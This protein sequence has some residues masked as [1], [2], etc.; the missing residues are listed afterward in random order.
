MGS[1]SLNGSGT[2]RTADDAAS[3]AKRLARLMNAAHVGDYTFLCSEPR[4]AQDEDADTDMSRVDVT[5]LGGGR[6]VGSFHVDVSAGVALNRDPE[7][8]HAE[9]PDT[10]LLLPGYPSRPTVQLY[11]VENQMADKVCAMPLLTTRA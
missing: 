7:M 10:A 6:Q 9:R 5:V 1:A 3:Y 4:T 11:P 8:M 2:I